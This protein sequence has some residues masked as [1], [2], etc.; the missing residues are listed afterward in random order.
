MVAQVVGGGC[1]MGADVRPAY[2]IQPKLILLRA[3]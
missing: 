2:S 3:V 1:R